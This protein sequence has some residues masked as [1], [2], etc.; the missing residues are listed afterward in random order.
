[1]MVRRP[2]DARSSAARRMPRALSATPDATP[3]TARFTITVGFCLA[4]MRIAESDIREL[5]SSTPSTSG[6]ARSA[7]ERSSWSDSRVWL[8]STVYPASVAAA[9]AP[10][11]SSKNTGLEMSV[12]NRA[13][14]L[15]R[16]G[17][18]AKDWVRQAPLTYLY[19]VLLT[20]TTWLLWNTNGRLRGA[21][22]AEQSTSLHQ[23]GINP[24]A[25]L[26]R[27]AMYVLPIELAVW[28]IAFSLV[29]APMEHRFGWRRVFASFAIGHAIAVLLGFACYRLVNPDA[30]V[31]HEARVRARRLYEMEH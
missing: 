7:M 26:L 8:S 1:M 9:S 13:I 6:R 3:L 2:E 29:V 18:P 4:I 22:L 24:V 28:W 23:L 21:F 27:S 5:V 19:L 10:R 30:A 16:R 11:M 31:H 15:L 12:S 20:F 17:D 14:R 25:V